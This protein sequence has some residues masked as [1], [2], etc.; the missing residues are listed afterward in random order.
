VLSGAVKEGQAG[1][2]P[3]GSIWEVEEKGRKG[4]KWKD[5]LQLSKSKVELVVD[6]SRG[7]GVVEMVV[8]VF[9]SKQKSRSQQSR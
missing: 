2:V 1:L 8:V 9:R 4:L 7:P 3:Y 6:I 5:Q